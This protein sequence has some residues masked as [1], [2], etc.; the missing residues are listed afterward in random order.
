VLRIHAK[1]LPCSKVDFF[2][3]WYYRRLPPRR[4]WRRLS[5]TVGVRI[6]LLALA[7][8]AATLNGLRV[9]S[10]LKLCIANHPA[11]VFSLQCRP[12][13]AGVMEPTQPNYLSATNWYPA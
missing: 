7:I 2:V 4:E 3:L 13:T 5:A 9:E 1:F 10:G 6:A 11:P 12:T 8:V